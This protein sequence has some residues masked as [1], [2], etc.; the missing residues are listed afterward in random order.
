MRLST[1]IIGGCREALLRR[2]VILAKLDGR[3]VCATH[4]WNSFWLQRSDLN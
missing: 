3:V 4:E 1:I 2:M